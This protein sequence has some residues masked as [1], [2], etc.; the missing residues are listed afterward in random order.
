MTLSAF[1][2]C[3]C[4]R[5]RLRTS[6]S[7]RSYGLKKCQPGAASTRAPVRH[8]TGRRQVVYDISKLMLSVLPKFKVPS[9]ACAAGS[10]S[11]SA[12]HSRARVRVS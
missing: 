11:R 9:A 8:S 1:P 4:Y 2:Y 12:R 6:W 3:D 10:L 5:R 7:A